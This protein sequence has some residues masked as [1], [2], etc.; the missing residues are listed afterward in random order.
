MKKVF[1]AS[2]C[3]LFALSCTKEQ[4]KTDNKEQ[5]I[6]L[7]EF[8]ALKKEVEDL[9]ITI[10]SITGSQ[11]QG[12]SQS[13]FDA[14][15]QENEELK[16]QVELLTSTFFEVDGLRFNQ[17]GEVVS[18]PK[19]PD[20]EVIKG[21]YDIPYSVTR[22]HDAQ[23]RL[24]ECYEEYQYG[25]YGYHNPPFLWNKVTYEYNGKVCRVTTQTH[26]YYS[27]VTEP[28]KEVVTETTYW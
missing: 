27:H 16:A 4:P 1:I 10:S 24:I 26:D 11:E 17:N 2:M 21:V 3:F 6:P 25:S 8:Q 20:S 18:T 9:T 23:G 28:A 12:V 15:K 13:D 7:S 19:L 14:L 5:N 22:T